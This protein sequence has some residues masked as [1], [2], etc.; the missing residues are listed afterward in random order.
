MGFNDTLQKLGFSKKASVVFLT[1]LKNGEMSASE[2]AKETK[3]VRTTVYD[4]LNELVKEEF[5]VVSSDIG[6]KKKFAAGDPEKLVDFVDNQANKLNEQKKELELKQG[7]LKEL[8]PQLKAMS[9]EIVGKPR[10]HFY[11]GAKGL[12]QALGF[13]LV[14]RQPVMIYGS[15]DPWVRWM[16][17]HFEWYVSEAAKRKVDIRRIDQKSIGK[18]RGDLEE[19]DGGWP[20]RYLPVGFALPGF[21]LLYGDKILQASFQ[22]PMA[23][24]IEDK[25]MAN[26]QKTVYELFWQFLREK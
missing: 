9:D 23:T 19:K 7:N 21:T 24:I 1:L 13:C 22:R 15:L 2:I 14:S 6:E 25:E 4:I 17:D 12:V 11:D 10:T 16:P 5:V 20:V 8:I 3:I 26:C 18:L